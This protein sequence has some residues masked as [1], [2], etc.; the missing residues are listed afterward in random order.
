MNPLLLMYIFLGVPLL[1]YLGQ[2]WFFYF[3]RKRIGMAI[4]M[5]GYAIGNIGLIIDAMERGGEE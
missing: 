3:P 5:T 2:G 4:A 1:M